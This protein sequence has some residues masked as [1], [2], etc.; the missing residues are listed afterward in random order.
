ME[1]ELVEVKVK[2]PRQV[3]EFM[4]A[5]YSFAKTEESFEEWLGRPIV[6]QTDAC[7]H[8]QFEGLTDAE[9]VGKK[10]GLTPEILDC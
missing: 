10:H 2:I 4:E 5:A 3:Y 8:S 7:L 1:V 6:W 9:D